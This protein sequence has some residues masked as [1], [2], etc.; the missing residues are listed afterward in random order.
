MYK[1]I[2]S[3]LLFGFEARVN[4][5]D[6]KAQVG[7]ADVAESRS[8]NHLRKLVLRGE[9]ANALHQVL[10]RVAVAGDHLAHSGNHA[11]RVAVVDLAQQRIRH[12]AEL[13][14]QKPPTYIQII[15]LYEYVLRYM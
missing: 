2:C 14:A 1:C 6:T 12:L 8:T 15:T 9:L 3:V 10:V 7:V 13:Q 4:C 11:E 5:R